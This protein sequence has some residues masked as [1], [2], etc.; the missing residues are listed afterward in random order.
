M[1]APSRPD[2]GP[3]ET[4]RRTPP[5]DREPVLYSPSYPAPAWAIYSARLVTRADGTASHWLP[6]I[7]PAWGTI[8]PAALR[9]PCRPSVDHSCSS[10]AAAPPPAA[11][12]RAA[13]PTWTCAQRSRL[14]PASCAACE[15][16]ATPVSAIAAGTVAEAERVVAA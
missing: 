3:V 16:R 15:E 5:H 1:E 11:L 10:V 6:A 8:G 14:G 9:R 2:G 13:R 4:G 12:R 7:C